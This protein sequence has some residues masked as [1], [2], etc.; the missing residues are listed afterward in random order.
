MTHLWVRAE[1]RPH[2]ARVGLTPEG[3]AALIA[4]RALPSRSRTA[5]TAPSRSTAT[6]PPGPPSP[7][8]GHGG[9]A[10]RHHRLRP[11]GAGGGRHA[12][13][14][15]PHH[16]RPRLQGPARRA[17]PPAPLPRGRRHALRSG[18]PDRRDRPPRRRLRLLGGLCGRGALGAGLGGAAGGTPRGPVAPVPTRRPARPSPPLLAPTGPAS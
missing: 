4:R 3:A 16:V 17:G 6:A 5:R 7:R 10:P 8:P 18:I 2:E 1:E 13:H 9:T 15:P 11:E 12:A 14:P